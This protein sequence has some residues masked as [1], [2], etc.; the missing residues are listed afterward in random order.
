MEPQRG[1]NKQETKNR[2]TPA[3]IKFHNNNDNNEVSELNGERER[4]RESEMEGKAALM[5]STGRSRHQGSDLSNGKAA[6][7]ARRPDDVTSRPGSKII[8]RG[9]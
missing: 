4:E 8:D 1:S 3:G 9:S 6:I 2:Q 5:P 7:N